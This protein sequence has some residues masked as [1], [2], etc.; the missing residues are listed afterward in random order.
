MFLLPWLLGR[1]FDLIREEADAT[2]SAGGN[3]VGILLLIAGGVIITGLL[4]GGF[5]FGV[6][7]YSQILSQKA[8]YDI[9]NKMYDSI[10]VSYTHLR[11]HETDS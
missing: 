9:R 11:A 5:M 3:I 10:P 2:N 7:Y 4:R 8:A 6:T 1:S